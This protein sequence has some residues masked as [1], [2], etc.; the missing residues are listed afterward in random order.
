MGAFEILI[1]NMH[2]LGVFGF[3]LPWIFTFTVL[4]AILLKTKALGE[5]QRIIGVISLV[6]AFFTI[7]FGG[8]AMAKFFTTFFGILALVIAGF[9][10][11]ILMAS[12]AGADIGKTLNKNSVIA[13]LGGII[14]V[15][16]V[17]SLGSYG[18]RIN[19]SIISLAFILILLGVAVMFITKGNG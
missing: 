18:L 17:I 6:V 5:D 9:L 15:I 19:E 2:Q 8:P 4:F 13:L 14:I 10:G 7:A 12:L 16:F 1:S 11:I 3:L